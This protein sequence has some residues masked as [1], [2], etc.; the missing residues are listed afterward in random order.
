MA[1]NSRGL[2]GPNSQACQSLSDGIPS[3]Q[4]VD[5]ITQ[6]GAIGKLASN[7]LHSIPLFILLTQILN[8]TG[9]NTYPRACVT[10]LHLD[11]ELMTTAP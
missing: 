3:F 1:L 6:L 2:R 4:C 10:A 7:K 9:P 8:S 11:I 5:L